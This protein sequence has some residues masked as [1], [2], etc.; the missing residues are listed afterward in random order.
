M[1]TITARRVQAADQLGVGGRRGDPAV[2]AD[3]RRAPDVITT[4]DREGLLPAITF[5]FS[6]SG[7]DAAVAQCLRSPLRLTTD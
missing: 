7:C 2:G 1:P 4:L 6:R 5:I 3:R